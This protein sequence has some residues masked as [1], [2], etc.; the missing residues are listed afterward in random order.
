MK[1]IWLNVPAVFLCGLCTFECVT[2]SPYKEPQRPSPGQTPPVASC[3]AG[4]GW[5]VFYRDIDGKEWLIDGSRLES[6]GTMRWIWTVE[7]AGQAAASVRIVRRWLVH[8]YVAEMFEI[9]HEQRQRNGSL[10]YAENIVHP[11]RIL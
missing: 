1:L 5:E 7:C 8:C 11:Y 9:R 6:R 3:T 4:H 2:S 10:S